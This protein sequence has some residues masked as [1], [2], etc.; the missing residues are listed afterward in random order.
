MRKMFLLTIVALSLCMVWAAPAYAD[1]STFKYE[2]NIE[3]YDEL[4]LLENEYM[5]QV[6]CEFIENHEFVRMDL[7][8]NEF[9]QEFRNFIESAYCCEGNATKSLN[10][11]TNYISYEEFTNIVLNTYIE[12]IKYHQ[13]MEEP[14]QPDFSNC[15]FR[16]FATEDGYSIDIQIYC[17]D[18][19]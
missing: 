5:E 14:I 1:N 10:I 9:A 12:F 15:Y 11:P 2:S 8:E 3:E 4:Y 13:Y 7:T 17:K 19:S 16:P 18:Y 6:Y